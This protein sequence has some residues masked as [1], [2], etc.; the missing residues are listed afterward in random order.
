ME[1][2][3]AVCNERH[4]RCVI[5]PFKAVTPMDLSGERP[6][7]IDISVAVQRPV[8]TKARDYLYRVFNFKFEHISL[9]KKGNENSMNPVLTLYLSGKGDIG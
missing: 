6:S 8:C 3:S 7:C 1:V 2:Y 5:I 9:K 4:V